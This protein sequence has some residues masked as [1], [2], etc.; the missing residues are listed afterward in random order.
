MSKKR[1]CPICGQDI[2][3]KA[4]IGVNIEGKA[5]RCCPGCANEVLKNGK[6]NNSVNRNLNRYDVSTR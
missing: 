3:N 6:K 5:V 1:R 2:T 4:Y